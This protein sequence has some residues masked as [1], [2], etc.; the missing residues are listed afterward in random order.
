MIHKNIDTK[1][2]CAFSAPVKGS[3]AAYLTMMDRDA[4]RHLAT[5]DDFSDVGYRTHHATGLIELLSYSTLAGSECADQE[6]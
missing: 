6:L 3:A 4:A 1:D 2:H 5:A